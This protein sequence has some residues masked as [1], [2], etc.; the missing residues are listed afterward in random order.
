MANQA[1]LAIEVSLGSQEVQE[2]LELLEHL[3]CLVTMA[4]LVRMV[5]WDHQV[6]LVHEVQLV[7]L[8]MLDRQVLRE[9]QDYRVQLVIKDL[10]VL[11]VQQ[12]TKEV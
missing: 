7:Y 8:E 9:Q 1:P 6:H 2:V 5:H 10:R 12:E 3:V 11:L 4:C